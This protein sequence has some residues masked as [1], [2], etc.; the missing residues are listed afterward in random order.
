MP[1]AE[2]TSSERLAFNKSNLVRRRP[3]TGS[4]IGLVVRFT[5]NVSVSLVFDV[6]QPTLLRNAAMHAVANS[7]SLVE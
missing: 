6:R 4:R 1:T 5:N 2:Q 3:T 7:V